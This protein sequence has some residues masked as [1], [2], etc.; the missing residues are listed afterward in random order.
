M[1]QSHR[2]RTDGI[3]GG[4]DRSYPRI[5]GGVAPPEAARGFCEFFHQ[6]VRSL[7]GQPKQYDPFRDGLEIAQWLMRV[8]L[9]AGRQRLMRTIKPV[10]VRAVADSCHALKLY[11]DNLSVSIDEVLK[12]KPFK[13]PQR[14]PAPK[15]LAWVKEPY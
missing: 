3:D 12:R 8:K 11:M 13:E 6:V 5:Y 10:D 15:P 14:P 1:E 4:G 2:R 9:R 7:S